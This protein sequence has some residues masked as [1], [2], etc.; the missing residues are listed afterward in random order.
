MVVN[1]TEKVKVPGPA[2]LLAM[3]HV[4][5]AY[6]YI[7][8]RWKP[9]H[10]SCSSE[11][12]SLAILHILRSTPEIQSHHQPSDL[13]HVKGQPGS[14][15]A[16]SRTPFAG[17]HTGHSLLCFKDSLCLTGLPLVTKDIMTLLCTSLVPLM[18][19]VDSAHTWPINSC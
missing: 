11:T 5:I 7:T 6:S 18:S 10:S 14:P 19:Q 1:I 3:A 2:M 4:T 13:H 15:N 8:S 16:D 17:T 9:Q 12:G